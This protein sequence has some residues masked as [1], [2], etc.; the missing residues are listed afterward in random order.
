MYFFS[1]MLRQHSIKTHLNC[2][3]LYA[4]HHMEIL[5]FTSFFHT[6]PSC[7]TS[8]TCHQKTR[9]TMFGHA[10]AHQSTL[11]FLKKYKPINAW[12]L[13]CCFIRDINDF[14]SYLKNT[15]SR[16]I[17]DQ[18]DKLIPFCLNL[19]FVMCLYYLLDWFNSF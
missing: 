4:K 19:A 12:D 8:V 15:I 16:L 13:F 9:F 2:S 11:T 5:L 10:A 7:R 18:C 17:E 3:T 1:A 6:T 14:G